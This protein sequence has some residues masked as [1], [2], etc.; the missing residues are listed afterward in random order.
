MKTFKKIRGWFSNPWRVFVWPFV[1]MVRGIIA[2]VYSS[3]N[4]VIFPAVGTLLLGMADI[5]VMV[6]VC[7]WV[8]PESPLVVLGINAVFGILQCYLL[9]VVSVR[10]IFGDRK[11]ISDCRQDYSC[12]C[13]L[14]R[15]Q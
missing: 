2:F 5:V 7:E 3:W 1:K 13:D 10:R 6:A 8:K 12:I 11:T 15:F 9:N 14:F 4:R